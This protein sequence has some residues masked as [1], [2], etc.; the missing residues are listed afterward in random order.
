MLLPKIYQDMTMPQKIVAL[1]FSLMMIAL[2]YFV[3]IVFLIISSPLLLIEYISRKYKK[4]QKDKVF[5]KK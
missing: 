2:F 3:G 1:L 5:F 4:Y